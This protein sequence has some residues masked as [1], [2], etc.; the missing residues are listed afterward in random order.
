M[1]KPTP[2]CCLRTKLNQGRHAANVLLE[3]CSSIVS[4]VSKARIEIDAKAFVERR[5]V[6]LAEVCL[7]IRR[8]PPFFSPSLSAV[9]A[10]S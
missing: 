9:A 2:M 7:N 10:S 4:V 3:E 5:E 1:N 6:A 8:R